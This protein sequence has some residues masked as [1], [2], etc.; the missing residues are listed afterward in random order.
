[1]GGSRLLLLTP[2][3]IAKLKAKIFPKISDTSELVH[4]KYDFQFLHI[5]FPWHQLPEL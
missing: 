4:S 1:M 2:L 3:L 5:Y